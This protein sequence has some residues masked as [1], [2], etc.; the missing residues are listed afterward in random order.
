MKPHNYNRKLLSTTSFFNAITSSSPPPTLSPNRHTLDNSL[1]CT[2]IIVLIGLAFMGLY[3]FYLHRISGNFE[4]RRRGISRTSSPPSD[5]PPRTSSSNSNQRKGVDPITIMALP[6][7]SYRGDAKYQI[8]CAIC[9]SEFDENEAVK[10]IPFCKHVFHPECID[11]WLSAHVTCPVCRSTQFFEGKGGEGLCVKEGGCD[12]GV[13]GS[14]E[15]STV[16]NNDACIEI[17]VVMGSFSVRRNSSCSN[18]GERGSM[19]RTFSF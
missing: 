12:H 4:E 17:R 18:L 16:G 2:L 1:T 5:L 7:Y 3:A 9:L 10:V 13:S 14:G 8:D 15:R 6:V 11:T 19:Q